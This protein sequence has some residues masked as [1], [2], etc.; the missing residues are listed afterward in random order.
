[1]TRYFQLI[2]YFYGSVLY[3]QD[4]TI[5]NNYPAQPGEV[6]EENYVL[7]KVTQH[8]YVVNEFIPIESGPRSQLNQ[9]ISYGLRSYIDNQYYAMR[10]SV[11]ALETGE[12]FNA[13]AAGIVRNAIW[14]HDYP[15]HESFSGFSNGLIFK[16]SALKNLNGYGVETGNKD[17]QAPKNGKVDLYT[18]QR[19]VYDLKVSAEREV[20]AFLDKELG[21]T[22]SNTLV[23]ETTRPMLDQIDF[24]MAER[25]ENAEEL[26]ALRPKLDDFSTFGKPTRKRNR[27]GDNEFS[28]RIVQLLEENNK[29]LANYG[30]RFEDMQKQID[31]IRSDRTSTADI[32]REEVGALRD[33]IRDVLAGRTVST[34]DGSSLQR[35][36]Q[37]S[38]TVI[39]EKNEH[40]LSLV[41]QAQLNKVEMDIR[42][43]PDFRAIIT[44][45][46]DKTGNAE[47]NAWISQ[48][49]AKAVR[50]Y[51][52]GKG[53]S[54]ERLLV[55]FL[56]DGESESP[57]PADRK[58]EV[59]LIRNTA[60]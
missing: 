13:S 33:M 30:Y 59:V 57:N 27:S 55:N 9:M 19:M 60:R 39:F 38:V 12:D 58:V 1:M 25:A 41:H 17:P 20:A 35:N 28:E 34:A 53:I 45:Y 22:D 5:I 16:A 14:I 31:E 48:Q 54:P 29:I 7:S 47:F 52:T 6:S 23:E 42:L 26:A 32:M 46:A 44:G 49:R 15:F 8:T 10:G 37:P 40:K 2:L 3:A 50:D 21:T 4:V 11:K 18:F 36:N 56:G 24:R 51:L 43:N